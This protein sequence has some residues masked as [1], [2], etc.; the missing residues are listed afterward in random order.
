MRLFNL[1]VCQLPFVFVD[2]MIG[3]NI[4]SR[5]KIE[6]VTRCNV[7]FLWRQATI[8][9]FS[10]KKVKNGYLIL[11]TIC[12]S[13]NFKNYHSLIDFVRDL[14]FLYKFLSAMNFRARK[15]ALS[16]LIKSPSCV[17][18]ST[19]YATLNAANN[20]CTL[21]FNNELRPFVR[22]LNRVSHC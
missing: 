20:A 21:S 18:P 7:R 12:Q 11:V 14:W 10:P 4:S 17:Y 13:Y 22:A 2:D 6:A 9:S 16:S 8:F 3:S 1:R 5:Q 15:F 19:N